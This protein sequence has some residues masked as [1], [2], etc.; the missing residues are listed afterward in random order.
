LRGPGST[1]IA[2]FF[3]SS[4]QV[5]VTSSP[6]PYTPAF[7]SLTSTTRRPSLVFAFGLRP[8][9]A[10]A[11]PARASPRAPSSVWRGGAIHPRI[12]DRPPRGKRRASCSPR[13]RARPRKGSRRRSGTPEKRIRN[14]PL[15]RPRLPLAPVGLPK[16]AARSRVPHQ[17]LVRVQAERH[18]QEVIA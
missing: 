14:L 10:G 1:R 4:P 11:A 18:R 13:A 5:T 8:G 15:L 12:P 7:G 9:P 17:R 6:S 16:F 2:A 3:P